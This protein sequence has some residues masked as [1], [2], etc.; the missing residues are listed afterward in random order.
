MLFGLGDGRAATPTSVVSS[1]AVVGEDGC[2]NGEV[3]VQHF[4]CGGELIPFVPYKV[5]DGKFVGVDLDGPVLRPATRSTGDTGAASCVGE[6]SRLEQAR[7]GGVSPKPSRRQSIYL[8]ARTVLVMATVVLSFACIR[9]L[10]RRF[11]PGD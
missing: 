11:A 10:L 2:K 3:A 9:F 1:V 5:A 4:L 7:R 6:S 8:A